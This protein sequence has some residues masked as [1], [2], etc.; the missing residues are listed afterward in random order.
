M[1]RKLFFVAYSECIAA[2]LDKLFVGRTIPDG[3]AIKLPNQKY[4]ENF[5]ASSKFN[6][7]LNV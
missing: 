2:N 3:I 1:I 7:M 4:P 6:M 5:F